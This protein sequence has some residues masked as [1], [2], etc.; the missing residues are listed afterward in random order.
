MVSRRKIIKDRQEFIINIDASGFKDFSA[1][2]M[3]LSNFVAY[4]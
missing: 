2:Y 3:D 4:E 1:Q